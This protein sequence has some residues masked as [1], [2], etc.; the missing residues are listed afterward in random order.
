MFVSE[1]FNALSIHARMLWVGIF[2]CVADDHGR[3][4]ASTG[5][6]KASIFPED[7]F[8][9]AQVQKWLDE[10]VETRMI[11]LYQDGK[12]LPLFQIPSWYT[13]QSLRYRK[14]SNFNEPNDLPNFP[15]VS[16]SFRRIGK[17]RIGLDRVGQDSTPLPPQAGDEKPT[18][19]K[20]ETRSQRKARR[21]ETHDE[22]GW[23]RWCEHQVT[24]ASPAPETCVIC[25]AK[26]A[27]VAV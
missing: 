22:H 8:R 27:E 15:K 6:L 10:I 23:L 12:G 25:R 24:G 3:G 9:R 5:Y 26:E 17:D 20:R 7:N 13:W 4:K 16:E 14:T 2:G 19:P 18:S 1:D 21:R 11:H